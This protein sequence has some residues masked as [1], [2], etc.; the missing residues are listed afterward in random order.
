MIV[1]NRRKRA[2]YLAEEERTQANILALARSAVAQGTASPAQAALVTGIAEE[3]EAF[4]KKKAERKLPSRLMWWMHGDWKE[5][6]EI[7]EQRKLAVEDIRRQ[8][9]QHGQ[10]P[11]VAV[12]SSN[13]IPAAGGPVDMAAEK[14]AQSAEK[15]SKGWLGW[16]MS[17]S[18][19]E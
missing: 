14:L 7:K 13:S 12:S 17:G 1:Y 11:G 16:M 6:K 3:E 10:I 2:I 5:E 8:E 15:T 18:K 4:E 9:L 19:K